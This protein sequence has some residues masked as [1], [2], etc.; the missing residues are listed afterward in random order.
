M[1]GHS[2]V[3]TEDKQG[4]LRYAIMGAF[5]GMNWF[6]AESANKLTKGK[7]RSVKELNKKIIPMIL[8]IKDNETSLERLKV[9]PVDSIILLKSDKFEKIEYKAPDMTG[10]KYRLT[11]LLRP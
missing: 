3:V 10:K 5:D 11:D 9:A 4:K 1:Y 8:A 7:T 2:L 6:L